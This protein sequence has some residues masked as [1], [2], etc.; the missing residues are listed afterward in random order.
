MKRTMVRNEV[1]EFNQNLIMQALTG[2]VRV[3]LFSIEFNGKPKKVL[4]HV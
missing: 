3:F 4:K 2:H 1:G